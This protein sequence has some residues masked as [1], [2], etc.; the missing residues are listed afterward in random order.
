MQREYQQHL[1]RILELNPNH[2]EARAALGFH[3][4]DGQWMNRDD[5]MAARGLVMYEGRYV[6]PQQVEILE[7]Q[8]KSRVTQA[9]WNNRIEQLRQWL[10]VADRTTTRRR[11]PKFKR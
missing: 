6:T 8:K 1:E 5:V 4:K 10:T 3:K 11:A 9:D 2:A 7:Q